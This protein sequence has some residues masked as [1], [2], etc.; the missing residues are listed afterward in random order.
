[1]ASKHG[2]NEIANPRIGYLDRGGCGGVIEA[3][4]GFSKYGANPADTAS[5]FL[6]KK[7]DHRA[8]PS[9]VLVPRITAAFFKMSFSSLRL[10][11]SRRRLVPLYPRVE[12]AAT[13]PELFS[14]FRDWFAQADKPNGLAFEF[15]GVSF[16][17][18]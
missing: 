5:G 16:S 9:W 11:T 18:H 17:V 8:A 15:W 6:N 10:V 3:A 1:M 13:N 7:L 4:A 12:D 2:L 14:H